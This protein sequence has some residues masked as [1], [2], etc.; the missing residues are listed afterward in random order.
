MTSHPRQSIAS[1]G[2]K[3]RSGEMTPTELA[4][5][6]VSRLETTGRDLNAVTTVT[7]ELALEEAHRAEEELSH[8]V[9]RGP[10]HG[11]PYGAKDLLATRGIPTS[12]G[13][14]PFRDRVID[15]DAAVI[16]SLRESGAVLAGKLAM[17]E[18][19]GGFGYNQTNATFTGPGK[20]AVDPSA[21]AGG[22]SSGSGAA[23]AAGCIPFAIG[24][25][26]WGSIHIPSS[27][28]GLTGFRPTYGVVSKAGAMALSW[29]MD[30][31]G[32]MCLT[33]EDCALVMA[34]I[35]SP[36][37]SSAGLRWFEAP[38]PWSGPLRIAVLKG[39]GEAAQPEVGA[40]FEASLK[41]LEQFASLEEVVLPDIPW[42]DLARIIVHVEGAAAFEDFLREGKAAELTA[43]E[44]RTGLMEG[45][46]VPAVDYLRS[47]RIRY[48][49]MKAMDEMLNGFDAVVAPSVPFVA[50]PID[51]TFD[52]LFS[53]LDVPTLGA[54]GNLCGLPSI[55]LPNGTG[56]RGLPTSLEIL[57]RAWDDPKV[58][59]FG[60]RYQQETG[61]S[62]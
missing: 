40:N 3:I 1:L 30:K 21:W 28:N 57:G 29:T 43:P 26:T 52:K 22:S 4:H 53:R 34:A 14:A 42:V 8:G 47:M 61:W 16:T 46:A 2:R 44:D 59:S 33:A 31:I 7:A 12:W 9:D 24:T 51:A 6:A 41:V 32:P 39:S 10:L 27:F 50:P 49:G 17:V 36:E 37:D 48:H 38:A 20:N 18:G 11:I 23:V 60:M 5:E 15:E 56:E 35:A 25:E 62:P 19:A 58:I 45:F 54:A 55:S 13:M